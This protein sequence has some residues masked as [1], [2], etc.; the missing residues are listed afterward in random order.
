MVMRGKL[1]AAM[2]LLDSSL[3]CSLAI[4]GNSHIITAEVHMVLGKLQVRTGLHHQAL[5]HFKQSYA[6]Y[7]CYFGDAHIDTAKSALQVSV[8]LED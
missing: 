1:P 8:I 2:H 6:V 3:Q 4:L 7:Q 5:T